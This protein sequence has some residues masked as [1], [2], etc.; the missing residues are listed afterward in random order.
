MSGFAIAMSDEETPNVNNGIQSIGDYTESS[1]QTPSQPPNVAVSDERAAESTLEKVAPT[2]DE[3]GDESEE[4][5]D[6]ED[7]DDED[8]EDDEEEEEPRLKYTR[9]TQNLGAV[10][11]NGDA[12]SSFL[13]AGD[14]MV[15][16][17]YYSCAGTIFLLL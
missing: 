12:T 1:P 13:V 4:E 8:E 17:K 3:D 11:K 15:M 14:K 7:D 2:P 16:R 6:D 9:L 5:E 10:Y